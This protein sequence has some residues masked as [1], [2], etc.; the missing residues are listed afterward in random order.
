V[1]K[2]VLV[3]P[4]D[5]APNFII[6]YFQVPAGEHTFHHRHPHEHG[7]VILHGRAKVQI[8]GEFYDVGALDSIF[9]TG[10]D[11]HQLINTGDTPLGFICVITRE[12]EG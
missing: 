12:A 10:N 4:D 9:I 11:V 7:M 8:E 2:H 1:V 5:G 3:G 6:R